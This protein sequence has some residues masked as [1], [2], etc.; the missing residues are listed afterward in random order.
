MV[1]WMKEG[2][3]KKKDGRHQYINRMA[4]SSMLYLGNVHMR[5]TALAELFSRVLFIILVMDKC[6]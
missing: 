5:G 1:R 2:Q 3:G 6:L 4:K